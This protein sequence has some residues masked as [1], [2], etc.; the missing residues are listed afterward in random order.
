MGAKEFEAVPTS[1]SNIPKK[2]KHI[3]FTREEI[4]NIGKYASIHGNSRA[5]PKYSV[6]ESTVRPH[7]KKHEQ[8]LTSSTK[9][10]R[11]RPLLLGSEIDEKVMEYLQAI[12]KKEAVVN[13]VV[14]IAIA[15][16]QKSE[17][18]GS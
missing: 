11:G 15:Q 18:A 8:G 12:R 7:R 6:G 9:V 14:K 5:A 4:L 1:I 16:E 10:K 17:S 2:R 3:T 13:T